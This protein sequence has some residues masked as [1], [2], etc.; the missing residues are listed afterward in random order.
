[1]SLRENAT[2]ITNSTVI[3]KDGTVIG[4]K[5][6]GQGPGVI[7]LHG[8]LSSSDDFTNFA[9]ELADSFTVHIID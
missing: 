1:M 4:Y 2:F 8:A 3:S 6:T 5:S 7:V 9:Q